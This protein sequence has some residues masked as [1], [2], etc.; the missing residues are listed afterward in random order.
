VLKITGNYFA[1]YNAALM[2]KEERARRTYLDV[3]LPLLQAAVPALA[4]AEAPDSFALEISHHVL[5]KVLGVD[6][7]YA[8]NVVLILPKASAQRLIAARD[9]AEREAATLEGSAYL[10]GA[11]VSF[12]PGAEDNRAET[13]SA[14]GTGGSPLP[15]VATSQQPAAEVL[16]PVALKSGA[17]KRQEAEYHDVLA[18]MVNDL[19]AQAH[20]V[21][22]AAPSF[23]LFRGTEYLQIP[24]VTTLAASDSGSQ[25]KLAALAFDRHV[26]HLI[27]PVLAYF[28]DSTDFAGIDFSTTVRLAG[29]N[30]DGG[31]SDS[32]EFIFPLSAL[33]SYEQ[34]NLTGQQLINAGVV[35]IN[36]ERAG[37]D[38]Q[39][40]EA[41]AAGK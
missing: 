23:I 8:E 19:D 32:V 35:L 40:A 6:T 25:Y 1:A 37:F 30:P 27:R 18:R 36:G 16:P 20:F 26:A 13:R 3:M 33:R 15:S 5:R 41:G 10:N 39:V 17:L 14:A 38:L 28:K 31:S 2:T 9:E 4:R 12:W 21:A 11:P 29:A 7:E 24:L 22:D 34:F